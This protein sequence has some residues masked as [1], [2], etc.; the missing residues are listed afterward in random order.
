MDFA[1]NGP[2]RGERSITHQLKAKSRRRREGLERLRASAPAHAPRNDP[3]PNLDLVLVP[4]EDLRMPP[5]QIR[6]LN[7]AHVREVANAISTLGFCAP[8]LIGGDNAV[9]DGAIR[10]QAARQLGLGRVPCVRIEHLS[11]MEKRV[12]RLAVN[13]LGEKGEW[14]LDELKVEFEE[15]IVADAPIEVSGFTLDEIDHIVLGEVDEAIEEGPLSPEASAIAVARIGDLFDLGP[16]RIICGSATDPET[17]RRL[18]AADPPARLVLTDEPYNVPIAGHVTG[19]HHREFAMASGEMTDAEFLTFNEAWMAAVLP[20]LCDGSIFGTFIDWRGYPTVHSAA[21]KLGLKP[22]NL[23]VWTKTNAGMGSLY[24]SQHE[25]LP[26]FKNGSAPHVN[27]IELGK[28]GR[29]RSNVWTYPGASSLGSDA[30]RGLQDH[31][32]VKPTA[33]LEDALLDLSDRGDIVID[34][35]LGSGST[36][37]ATHKTDRLCRGVELDPLYVDVIVRRFE[38]ATGIAAT[39]VETGETFEALAAGRGRDALEP[40]PQ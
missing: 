3:L 27:N 21:V 24:R 29:W 15:L 10:V 16:H 33:M 19:G 25:L 39:L 6:K 23:V 4:L 28:R 9:I 5:R 11:E 40:P 34:P 2:R 8:V 12:L 37:M 36:L 26:L 13:R 32:T 14:N 17:L 1:D 20:C 22:I 7:A 31:P 35:F 38:A 30:R 18:M